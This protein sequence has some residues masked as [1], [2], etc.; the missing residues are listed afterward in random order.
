MILKL[1]AV[2]IIA[3]V[4]LSILISA[5]DK[6]EKTTCLTLLKQSELRGFYVTP[7][8]YEMCKLQGIDFKEYVIAE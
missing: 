4:F 3:I 8:E 6:N 2:T 7:Y 5:V 1:L